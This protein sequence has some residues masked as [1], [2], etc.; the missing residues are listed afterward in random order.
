[1]K[2]YHTS[3]IKIETISADGRF[4]DVLFFAADPYYTTAVTSPVLYAI[5][6]PEDSTIEAC[7]LWYQDNAA[8]ADEIVADY[9]DLW[10]VDID[11]ARDLIDETR[12]AYDVFDDTERACDVSW[13]TQVA[14]ARCA[15]AMGYVGAEVRD[16]QGS[17][18]AIPMSRK[19][20]TLVEVTE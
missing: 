2:L 18:Y 5:D 4:E 9:A 7:R 3:P 20:S 8:C 16:E 6:I 10:D 13:Q 11:T 1:M 14:A 12:D 19:E 15:V 17:A